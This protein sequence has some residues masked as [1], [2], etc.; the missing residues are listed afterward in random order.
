MNDLQQPMEGH[1]VRALL[2]ASEGSQLFASLSCSIDGRFNLSF[3]GGAAIPPSAMTADGQAWVVDLQ[4]YFDS[5][6]PMP[7]RALRAFSHQGWL[8]FV[9]DAPFGVTSPD[10]IVSRFQR[11]RS[12]WVRYTRADGPA[13]AL[14]D[15][16]G[17]T[18]TVVRRIYG[19]CKRMP[20]P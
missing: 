13:M 4:L 1:A 9:P 3:E 19:A 20:P 6:P 14:F 11:A 2:N 5:A 16:P 7:V 18:R 12:M 15:V 17:D 8:R 10:S